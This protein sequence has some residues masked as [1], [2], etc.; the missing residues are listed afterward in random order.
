MPSTAG[1]IITR[2]HRM[3]DIPEASALQTDPFVT[4]DEALE[5][6]NEGLGELHDL[7]VEVYEEW[8]TEVDTSL[9]MTAAGRTTA[10][11]SDFFKLRGLFLLDG[12]QR[13]E[14]YPFDPLDIAGTTTTD[15]T[16]RPDYRIVG[17]KLYWSELPG[18][19]YSLEIWYV[20]QFRPLDDIADL[21]E[22]EIPEGW[23]LFVVAFLANYLLA[24]EESDTT[25][26]EKALARARR[27]IESAATNRDASRP[28][29]VRDVSGRFDTDRRGRRRR[30]LPY[31]R[32]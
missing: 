20:R 16:D 21:P 17:N 18:S 13:I 2:G 23:E 14:L 26:A 30:R 1:E 32:A 10:L 7:L 22:P 5:I 6:V 8:L 4:T 28:Q 24:K 29:Q 31:P 25:P 3:A 11:P 27:R 12:T 19:A 9:S 15:T